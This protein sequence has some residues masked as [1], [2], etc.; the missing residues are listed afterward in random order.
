MNTLPENLLRELLRQWLAAYRRLKA[1]QERKLDLFL[2][3][4]FSALEESLRVEEG[5]AAQVR[6]LQSRCRGLL[7]GRPLP[8]A[9]AGLEEPAR[10]ELQSRLTELRGL[11]LEVNRLN[12]RNYR[13]L[14]TSLSF[15][16]ALLQQL[17]GNEL[18]YTGDGYVQAG[19]D[20]KRHR[21][22][23]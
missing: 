16:Q 3:A 7:G 8:E 12:V 15:N 22:V 10:S 18:A 9:V 13:Y 17:L 20:I 1:E 6:Q 2:A 5:I 23:W 19:P 21:V 4:D 11:V 14:Q